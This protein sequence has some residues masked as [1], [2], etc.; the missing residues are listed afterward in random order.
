MSVVQELEAGGLSLN[1]GAS[2]VYKMM[3]I[4]IIETR[5][6]RIRSGHHYWFRI[7]LLF[8]NASQALAAADK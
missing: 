2:L 3:T 1:R 7:S 8:P 5:L 4:R 6:R